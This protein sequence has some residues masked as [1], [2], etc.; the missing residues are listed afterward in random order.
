MLIRDEV[1]SKFPGKG[2]KSITKQNNMKTLQPI[3]Y[4]KFMEP[5]FTAPLKFIPDPTLSGATVKQ[6]EWYYILCQ[7]LLDEGTLTHASRIYIRSMVIRIDKL[8]ERPTTPQVNEYLKI[9]STLAYE[10]GL[11]LEAIQQAGVPV[12]Y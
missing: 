5:E 11:T 9:T 10:L 1:L 3:N 2:V 12:L 8:P 6:I 7:M 4:E